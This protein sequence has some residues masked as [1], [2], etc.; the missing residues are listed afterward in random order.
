MIRALIGII[1]VLVVAGSCRTPLDP[2]EPPAQPVEQWSEPQWETVPRSLAYDQ[3]PGWDTADLEPGVQALRQSCDKIVSKNPN[4]FLSKRQLWGGRVS[5][6]IPACG[7]LS[8]VG[9]QGS[10]RAVLQA[11]FTPIR[12]N[13][14]GGNSRFTGYFEPTFQARL[15]PEGRFTDAVLPRPTDLVVRN[16]RVLQRR[17]DG[18]VSAYPKRAEIARRADRGF[19]YMRPEDLFFLQ[20]QGSGRLLL[21]DGRTIRAVYAANNGHTFVSTANWLMRK[22]WITRSQASM[23]GIKAWMAS[24]SEERLRAAMNANPRYIFF[25]QKPEGDPSL[26]PDGSQG[27]PLTPLGSIA[28]DPGFHPLGA[29]FFVKTSA[30]GLGGE[31][32]SLVVAQDTGN[33]IKG[34]VRA[35]IYFGTGDG[36]GQRA[37]TMNAPG[38][39]WILLPRQVANRLS[40]AS[41]AGHDQIDAGEILSLP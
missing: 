9:D 29:P 4:E 3:L 11:L 10:A 6:W 18:S 8:V 19:A 33:A 21:P 27:V 28:V 38:E 32:S 2:V 26:G 39:M 37:D 14:E 12:V 17:S 15:S 5:E 41:N 31:W 20:I 25:A 16:G 35:D 23:A 34:A 36:A 40:T 30:P 7:A 22:G 13:P 24:T 1:F